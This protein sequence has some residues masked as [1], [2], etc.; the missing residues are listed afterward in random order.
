M[1][2]VMYLEKYNGCLKCS[3]KVVPDNDVEL[4]CCSKCSMMQCVDVSTQELSAQLVIKSANGNVT[5]RAFS[6]TVQDIAD[7]PVNEVTMVVLLK[8]KPFM[9]VHHQRIIQSISRMA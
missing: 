2:G 5:L 6:K 7:K 8:A 1:V 9:L 3:A 4:G